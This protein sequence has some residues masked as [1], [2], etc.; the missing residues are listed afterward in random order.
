N[1]TYESMANHYHTI[2]LPTRVRKPKDKPSVENT[3][4]SLTT[5]IIAR[6]RNYQCFGLDD[7][8]EHLRKELDRFNQKPFQKKPGSRFSMFNDMERGALQPCRRCL[9]STVNIKR[10]KFIIIPTSVIKNIIILCR[11]NI[12][13]KVS[14]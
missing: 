6:M 7:Y 9:L 12:S 13:V 5:H 11:I 4:K 3:V 2:I 14:N 8:N 1:E 10:S